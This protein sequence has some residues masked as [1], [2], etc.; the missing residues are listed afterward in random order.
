MLMMEPPPLRTISG[1]ACLQV[2]IWLRR[3]TSMVRSQTSSARS[4]TAVSRLEKSEA[5]NAPLA[6]QLARGLVDVHAQDRGALAGEGA[7]RRPA[8]AAAAA[9]DDRDLV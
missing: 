7:R 8:D 3:L 9:G 1:T 5:V 4:V 2:S 6:H